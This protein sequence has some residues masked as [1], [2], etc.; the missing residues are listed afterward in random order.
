MWQRKLKCTAKVLLNKN[1]GG[2]R[3]NWPP[4][5][6][7]SA[8]IAATS[9]QWRIASPI[10]GGRRGVQR[11]V[12]FL[13]HKPRPASR[14]ITTSLRWMLV[15]FFSIVLAR[16]WCEERHVV[17]VL[18]SNSLARRIYISCMTNKLMKWVT[19]KNRSICDTTKGHAQQEFHSYKSP[20]RWSIKLSI[21][22]PNKLLL[23]PLSCWPYS[24]YISHIYTS[25]SPANPYWHPETLMFI[26][27]AMLSN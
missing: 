26:S 19:K 22:C 17:H 6:W 3:N 12:N 9:R 23:L 1:G 20:S 2:K 13:E 4:W 7:L 8:W 15:I 18:T 16:P 10:A 21:C 11:V 5:W 24:S 27:T 25:I 14:E